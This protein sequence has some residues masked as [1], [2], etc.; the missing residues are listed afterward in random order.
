[1]A[2]E[3]PPQTLANHARFFPGFHYIA[4]P[5]LAIV[6]FWSL[7]RVFTGFTVDRLLL[8]LLATGTLV[9]L[10]VARLMALTVQDRVIRLEMRLRLAQLLPNDL[11]PRLHELTPRQLVAL[12]FASDEELPDLVRTVLTD[13]IRDGR[14]IKKMI[15]KWEGDYLRA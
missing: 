15:R 6:F 3:H 12:R 7:W 4:F 1:M 14:A 11:R 9:L 13:N 5:I 8:A 10:F 2:V